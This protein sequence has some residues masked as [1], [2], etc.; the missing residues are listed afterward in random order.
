MLKEPF[1]LFRMTVSEVNTNSEPVGFGLLS[2]GFQHL[3]LK[4]NCLRYYVIRL[5]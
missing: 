3:K 2:Y 1:I 4:E 5:I